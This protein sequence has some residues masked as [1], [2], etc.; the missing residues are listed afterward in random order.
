LLDDV[1][2]EV[3]E[4]AREHQEGRV[5]GDATDVAT[6]NFTEGWFRNSGINNIV[7]EVREMAREHQEGRV[8]ASVTSVTNFTEGWF[9]KRLE[10]LKMIVITILER[11]G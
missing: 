11:G 1:A 10:T 7:T 6:F 2:T 3:L 9:L 4:M 8:T 5:A